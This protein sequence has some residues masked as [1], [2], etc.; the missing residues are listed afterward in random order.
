MSG[1]N[2]IALVTGGGSGIGLAVVRKFVDRGY[3]VI[4]CGRSIA[5]WEKTVNANEALRG[6][7]FYEVNLYD[8]EALERFFNDV[9]EKYCCLDI[10]VNN[11]ASAIEAVG[12]FA[13]MPVEKLR[14]NLENDLWMPVMCLRREV[15]MMNSG[16]SIVNVSSIN[17][18]RPKDVSAMYDCAN[19]GVESMTKSLALELI[20]KGIRVN[21]VA[22]GLILTPRW[23]PR[24]EGKSE[25]FVK[26]TE[27]R[28]P[29]KRFGTPEEVANGIVWLASDEASYVVGHTL[30]IDGGISL[31]SN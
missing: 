22:P 20:T 5:K 31:T 3:Q 30:I 10:A 14:A 7:D 27:E 29:I 23:E 12:P 13:E 16:S 19:A 28:T 18:V 26:Q 17:G 9:K 1:M 25:E 8:N 11:A 6:V 15:N 24:L 4:T 21:S 2:K